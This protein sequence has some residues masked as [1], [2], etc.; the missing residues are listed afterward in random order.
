MKKHLLA[1]VAIIALTSSG[2]FV[3]TAVADDLTAETAGFGHGGGG[4]GG[5]NNPP[6]GGGNNAYIYGNGSNEV[7]T[8]DQEGAGKKSAFISQ[9]NGDD[10]TAVVTQRG[11]NT[12]LGTPDPNNA[13]SYWSSVAQSGYGNFAS[14]NENGIDN[15]S[16]ISQNGSNTAWVDQSGTGNTSLINQTGSNYANVTQSSNSNTSD[17][18]QNGYGLTATVTQG[19]ASNNSAQIVSFGYGGHATIKQ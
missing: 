5:G 18:A 10:N 19:T 7:A 1:A 6:V 8:I 2:A 9:I 13:A 3:G 12:T 15:I 4:G 14:A 17:V 16:H 11:I